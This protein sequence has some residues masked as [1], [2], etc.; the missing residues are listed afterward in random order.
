VSF[1]DPSRVSR[2]TL[3]GLGFIA[4][5]LTAASCQKG[6]DHPPFL[7]CDTDCA[8]PTFVTIGT[9]NPSGGSS[10]NLG[11]AGPATLTGQVLLL[12]DATFAVGALYASSATITADGADGTPVSA[13][14]DGINNY[15]LQNVANEATNWIG[16]KPTLIG[17]PQ[18]TYQAIDTTNLSTVNVAMVSGATLDGVIDS[19]SL[20]RSA[21]EGQVVLN[22]QSK[23]THL[24]LAG[25]HV[26][27][28]QAENALYHAATTTA[29]WLVDDGTAITDQSGLVV[30]VNV[31]PGNAAGTQSVL[32]TKAA[33]T[34][35]AAVN[36][37][38]FAIK[39][40]EG[41]VTVASVAI[42]L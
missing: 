28:A 34:T 13:P 33:T 26:S 2:R 37:G 1:L 41:A 39:V 12:N 31:A 6:D 3:T 23:G 24:P 21:S 17:D 42:Q 20:L 4:L 11:D 30:F 10:S 32:V 38:T 36:G 15:L 18:L 22:F 5:C 8:P 9:G 7:A 16:V 25:L 27:M 35:A 14:W 40:A 29:P 19:V